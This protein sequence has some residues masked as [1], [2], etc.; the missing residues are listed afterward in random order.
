MQCIKSTLTDRQDPA[1]GCIHGRMSFFSSF[2]D[3]SW[4]PSRMRSN[5]SCCQSGYEDAAYRM[6]ESST[7]GAFLPPPCA[8]SRGGRSKR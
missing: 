4:N 1:T 7:A 2:L 3:A 8:N 5:S 6:Q